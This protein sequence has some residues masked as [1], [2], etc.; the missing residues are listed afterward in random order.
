MLLFHICITLHKYPDFVALR[1]KVRKTF[2]INKRCRANE[3]MVRR[4]TCVKWDALFPRDWCKEQNINIKPCCFQTTRATTKLYKYVHILLSSYMDVFWT[5]CGNFKIFLSLR[6]YVKSIWGFLKCK[7]Y[8]FN[9][10]I[11]SKFWF[12]WIF[13]LFEGWN[14]PKLQNS[15]E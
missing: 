1:H 9:T 14:F 5:Q 10:S 6:F 12:L 8:H 13:S 11:G 15:E 2:S 4:R 7:I 3:I